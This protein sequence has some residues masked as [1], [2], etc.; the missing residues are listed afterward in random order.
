MI[1]AKVFGNPLLESSG[2]RILEE[3]VEE[4]LQVAPAYDREA[5]VRIVPS[6]VHADR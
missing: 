3:I 6:M 2:C 1:Q 4:L 5:V